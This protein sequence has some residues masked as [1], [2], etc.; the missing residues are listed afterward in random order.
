[1]LKTLEYARGILLWAPQ[2]QCHKKKKDFKYHP[3]LGNDYLKTVVMYSR[4]IC[5]FSVT[6][7]R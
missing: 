4:I 6:A 7:F 1:M 3:V 5:Q 2:C